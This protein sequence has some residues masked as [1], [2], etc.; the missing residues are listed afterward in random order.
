LETYFDELSF[1]ADGLGPAA[2]ML[3]LVT[4]HPLTDLKALLANRIEID[5]FCGRF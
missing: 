1:V 3:D 5:E 2:M 4:K